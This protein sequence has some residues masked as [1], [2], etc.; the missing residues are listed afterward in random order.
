M[1]G[2]G[3]P[4]PERTLGRAIDR[5]SAGLVMLDEQLRPPHVNA[6]AVEL[7]G[8][9]HEEIVGRSVEEVFPS[10]SGPSL[11]DRITDVTETGEPIAF[12]GYKEQTEHWWNVSVYPDETSIFVFSVK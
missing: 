6:T 9:A 11:E 2:H 8:L 12:D 4:A 10:I 3:P 1:T 5:M 7:L